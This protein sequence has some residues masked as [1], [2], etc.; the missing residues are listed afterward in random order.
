MHNHF[1]K[2]LG[3]WLDKAHV[4]QADVNQKWKEETQQSATVTVRSFGS[5]LHIQHVGIWL[6]QT[7]HIK[8]LLKLSAECLG[9]DLLMLIKAFCIQWNPGCFFCHAVTLSSIII[10]LVQSCSCLLCESQSVSVA[11]ALNLIALLSLCLSD[12]H[13][14]HLALLHLHL[15]LVIRQTLIKDSVCFSSKF[16]YQRLDSGGCDF[17]AWSLIV[18]YSNCLLQ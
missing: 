13:S 6:L 12:S 2:V 3:K 4:S 11:C 15:V 8:G 1:Q 16:F 17:A 14:C 10:T 7:L 9:I 18:N 5:Q